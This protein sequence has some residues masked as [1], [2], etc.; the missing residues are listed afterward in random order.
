[1][2]WSCRRILFTRPFSSAGI[3]LYY[4]NRKLYIMADLENLLLEAAGRTGGAGRNR[5]SHPQSKRRREDQYSDD[6]SDSKDDDSDDDRGYSNRKPSGSQVPLK[7]RLEPVERE[8]DQGS[9]EEGEEDGSDREGGNSDESDVGSDL[10]KDEDDRQQL[11]QLSEL[12]REMILSDRASKKDDKHFHEKLRLKRDSGKKPTTTQSRKQTPPLTASRG[13]RSS[14]RSADRAAAKDDAL[15]E[16]RAK[17]LKQ[18]DPE[19]HRKLN[20]AS[21]GSSGGRG[22]S[23]TKRKSFT[24]ASASSTSQ[25]ESGSG[26]GGSGSE[27]EGSTGDGGMGDSDDET[28]PESLIPTFQEIKE[29][30]IRRSKL[31]KW[32]S[33]PFF[34][35][36]IVGCFVRVGIGKSKSGPIYRLCI[37]RNV[38]SSDPD[39]QYK[40]EN[41]TTHKFLNC[42]WGNENSAARWQMAMVSDS[43]PLEEEYNQWVREVERSSGKMPSKQD[44]STKKE[45]IQ[46]TNTFVYSAETVKQMLQ[47]KKSSTSRPLNIAA[48]KDR[49]RGELM[50]AESVQEQERIKAKLLQLEASRK[51]NVKDHKALKLAEMNRKNRAENFKNA[52]QM[53]P[54]NFG[55]KA[56]EAG[57][58]PF[59]RRWTRSRNYYISK[60]GEAE[61]GAEVAAAANGAAAD[62]NIDIPAGVAA[63]GVEATVAALEAA[64]DAGKL[65]DT[66]APVDRGTEMNSL[67]LFE[68]D[69]TLTDLH[70]FGGPQAAF[71]AR[72]QMIEATVG[73]KVPEDDGRRHALTLTVSDY[74]RRRGLL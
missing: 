44:V 55:L 68:L 22:S 63:G 8:D 45:A 23:P 30:T 43:A 54:A 15:N 57:Y 18:Q 39:R 62:M 60:P 51:T 42:V 48:E 66:S 16:L 49:L 11:A 35:D 73:C 47:E 56:G 10:Y 69:I 34:E 59:S 17:R 5:P 6:G 67:H 38:D 27:D 20:N 36:L 14:A 29:I 72:K 13:V 24:A 61:A 9:S 26:G 2:I 7:K 52:S 28:K 25:S 53:K 58:D 70:K 19:A 21:R 71:M 32:L 64:A 65:V 12:D 4:K 3:T 33:E 37:V 31:A 50:A 41:R 46:N 74:K 40:L 1:M